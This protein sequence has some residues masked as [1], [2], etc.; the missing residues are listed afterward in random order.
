MTEAATELVAADMPCVGCGYNLRM[1]PA[2]G[3]CPECAKPVAD[4]MAVTITRWG[5]AEIRKLG[6]SLAWMAGAMLGMFAASLVCE[7]AGVGVGDQPFLVLFL[8]CMLGIYVVAHW[9]ATSMAM[10]RGDILRWFSRAG[11]IAALVGLPIVTFVIVRI[12]FPGVSGW[13][14][15]LMV[16]W[17]M[18]MHV[19]AEGRRLGDIAHRGGM[20]GV[21]G[22]GLWAT[23]GT[24]FGLVVCGIVLGIVRLFPYEVLGEYSIELI[25]AGGGAVALVASLVSLGALIRLSRGLLRL[26]ALMDSSAQASAMVEPESRT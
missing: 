21:G 5:P 19:L 3:R 13:A 10:A 12:F 11:I 14:G 4:T 18:A 8:L 23:R 17:G 1:Q 2:N 22:L 16:F 15:P 20:N 9:R 24:C 7:L 26:A 25:W 6:R